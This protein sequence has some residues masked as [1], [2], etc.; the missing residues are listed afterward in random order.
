MKVGGFR[1]F[2]VIPLVLINPLEIRDSRCL[3]K[4]DKQV[5]V[6][7]LTRDPQTRFFWTSFSITKADKK[8]ASF[9]IKISYFD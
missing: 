8:L 4:D 5:C 3:W 1:R 6:A 7:R 9:Q 2:I